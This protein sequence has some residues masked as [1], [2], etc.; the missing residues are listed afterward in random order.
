MIERKQYRAC[1]RTGW[2]AETLEQAV[3]EAA[4]AARAAVEAG[5]ILT[6][7]LYR[8]KDMCFLYY[9]ALKE[10]VAP[11]DF[12]APLTPLLEEWPEENGKTPWAYM[13]HIFHHSVPEDA[14]DWIRERT[15]GKKRIGR[16]AFLYP[17]KL[18]SYTYWHYAIVEEGLLKGDKYQCIAL[19]ENILFS[20]F[21]EPRFNVNI[22]NEPEQAS[23]V[24]EGWMEAD[25]ESHFDRVKAG[26]DNFLIID[27]LFT[28][29]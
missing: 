15:E 24:I 12:L 8:Y 6:A 14:A 1:L 11:T 3:R 20:Y 13:Y 26:G 28:V 17:D 22:K 5:S 7:S 23:N 9:E 25:P 18:F 19:H 4:E 10:N 16:I 27:R 2:K 21:E 29:G